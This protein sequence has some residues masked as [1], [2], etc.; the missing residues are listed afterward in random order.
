MVEQ[1]SFGKS[2]WQ[3]AFIGGLLASVQRAA[4]QGGDGH[5]RCVLATQAPRRSRK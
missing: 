5:S 4:G 1:G 2:R 3:I